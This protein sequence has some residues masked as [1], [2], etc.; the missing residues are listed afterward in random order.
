MSSGEF[1]VA[2]K[3]LLAIHPDGTRPYL[4]G[5]D[6]F[7]AYSLCSDSDRPPCPFNHRSCHEPVPIQYNGETLYF[8]RCWDGRTSRLPD[9]DYITI[10]C[11]QKQKTG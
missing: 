5:G 8:I 1:K 10:E 11:D 7:C 9:T 6:R 3:E 4:V 2:S